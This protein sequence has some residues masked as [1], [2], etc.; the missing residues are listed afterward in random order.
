MKYLLITLLTLVFFTGCQDKGYGT[1]DITNVPT[2]SSNAKVSILSAIP[3]VGG[4]IAQSSFISIEFASYMNI[5]SLN[6]SNIYM[7]DAS[8]TPISLDVY[9]K[10][11]KLY[12]KPSTSLS[13]GQPYTLTLK[14]SIEDIL[15]NNLDKDYE[16]TFTC[17]SNFWQSVDAGDTH[18]IAQS[19][20]GDIYVWGSNG[21]KQIIDINATTLSTSIPL[22]IIGFNGAK[23]YS[24][25][26]GSSAAVLENG[27]L[28]SVGNNAL[29]NYNGTDISQV[30]LGK[31]HATFIKDDGTLWSW[32]KNDEGQ[33]GNN[34]IFPSLIP[35][36]EDT[37]TSTWK[38]VSAGNSF[39]IALK[40]D[41]TL[42][43]WG[44]NTFGQIGDTTFSQRRKPTQESS[45]ATNWAQVSAG[46][47]HSAMI[48]TDGTL[49]SFGN[50]D[51]GQLGNGANVSSA[52]AQQEDSNATT[53]V[54]VSA[55]YNHTCAIKTDGTLWCWGGNRF[56][57]LGINSIL[58]TNIPTQES[59]ND[60]SWRS[61]SV[62]KEFT[63]AT[64][65]DG[66]LWAWGYNAY[67]QLG[68]KN[69]QT[70]VHLPTEV[71]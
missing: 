69:N 20:D 43:G 31:G 26:Y 8:G 24:A 49:W 56:G 29:V 21:N 12:V 62:G 22:G 68:L 10:E 64:K 50:N 52:S 66:T 70:D 67:D 65:T 59:T 48:K 57:Q 9:A 40:D 4:N 1:Q 61:V 6:T 54:Q 39:T 27:S 58:N 30:S 38:Q 55:G 5:T 16:G 44:D 14:S 36:A 51:F 7:T 47:F 15:G 19:I 23:S 42:W 25:G 45:N 37:N 33:L 13:V 17:V 2:I 35:V 60:T 53:W 3:K 46:S 34:N 63:L 28:V 11:N 71:K 18:S 32:G 41:G